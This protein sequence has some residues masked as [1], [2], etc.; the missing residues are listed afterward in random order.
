MLTHYTQPRASK[1]VGG[2]HHLD[3]WTFI[4]ALCR[5]NVR[6]CGHS[7]APVYAYVRATA[8][9]PPVPRLRA[10]CFDAPLALAWTQD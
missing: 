8:K 9:G 6:P 7:S 4:T 2:L 5:R 1:A 3:V 10:S